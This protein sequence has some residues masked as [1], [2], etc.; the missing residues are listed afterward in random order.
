MTDVLEFRVLP[1]EI[2]Q[3]LFSNQLLRILKNPR[4]VTCCRNSM[5]M[6]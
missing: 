4:E 3:V 2:V 1:D 5:E 6:D